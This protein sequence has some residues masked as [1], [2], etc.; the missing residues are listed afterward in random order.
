MIRLGHA[1]RV[2]L[3]ELAGVAVDFL[4]VAI[5]ESP[6][7]EQTY[8]DAATPSRIST[9]LLYPPAREGRIAPAPLHLSRADE[10]R[11]IL[12]EVKR[13]I[14]GYEPVGVIATR[15]YGDLMTWLLELAGFQGTYTAGDATT[16]GPEQ[17]T[18][19]GVNALNSAVVNVASTQGFP[20]AGTF[21]MGGVATT[22]TG[23]TATS[24]TGCGN[25]AATVGGEVIN[26][27]VPAGAH[28]WV[29]RKRDS[30][31]AKTARVRT[32]YATENVLLEGYGFGVSSMSLSAAAEVSADLMGL[33]MRRLAADAVTV[34]AVPSSAI[35]PF[36]RGELY[37]SALAGG[38]VLSDFTLNVANPLERVA[39]M[40]LDPPSDWPDKLEHGDDQVSVSGTL[41]KRL[42]TGA[43]YDALLAATSFAMVAKW[44]SD[45]VI[46]ATVRPYSMHWK[47]PA[48]QYVGGEQDALA[49]RRRHGF[50]PDWFAAWDEAAGYDVE[51][52]LVNGV[53]AI[54]TFA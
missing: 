47:M 8:D 36:R 43:D 22:Y 5:E 32:N 40:S 11:G 23:K 17:T 27:H 1:R 46:G 19:S 35:P 51:I 25:H 28:K 15:A 30:T 7:N 20:A 12:G 53:A 4:Q 9:N 49:N 16:T 29:F 42:L 10:M 38:G 52:T 21:I 34:P 24:F 31:S 33:F 37:V 39:S 18:A 3:A 44:V 13:L 48:V 26:D 41:P 6:L 45:T 50:S 14:E 2:A 54:A